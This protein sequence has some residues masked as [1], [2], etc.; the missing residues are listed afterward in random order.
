MT[1]INKDISFFFNPKSIAVVGASPIAEKLSNVI[2]NSLR[3]IGFTG[4]IY[5]VNPKYKSI[6]EMKCY[7]SAKAIKA[8]VDVAIICVPASAVLGVMEDI[9]AKKVKGVIIVSA[10]FKETGKDGAEAEEELKKISNE[11]GIR[12]IGPNCLGIFDNISKVDTFFILRERAKRPPAGG[13]SILSQ[14]GSFAGT[15]MDELSAEG[16]GVARIINYGNRADVGESDCLEY[17]AEDKSTKVVGLYIESVDNGKIF[18]EAARRCS[19]K[20]PVF[21][22]KA[23]RQ[24]TGASAARSHTGAI[25]GRYEIYSA[26]FK[27]AGIIEVKGYSEFLD[28]CK[29]LSKQY[30]ADGKRVL[31]V[32]DGG[33]MGAS[34]ADACSDFGLVVAEPSQGIKDALASKLP[35]FC[36]VGNPIDLTGSVT[37]DNYVMA[38]KEAMSEYDAAIVM[39]L[40]GPP[41]LTD[42][43]IKM[44]KAASVGI[45]KPV[46][47]C[48]PGGE[49]SQK[50]K[51]MFEEAGL[52]V[53]SSPE[54][55]VRAAAILAKMTVIKLMY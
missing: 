45:K 30:H 49:Y 33:G 27:K 41:L 35:P 4:D 18:I 1:S 22:I 11:T 29:V 2:I 5:P 23:G 19:A 15:I 6:D 31:I 14:S 53:F 26:A 24:E 12:I 38:L 34:I 36:A 21:A 50:R 44:L 25:A 47:I 10:G 46:I 40:W 17:M 20:K 52:P 8:D 37:N 55:A 13:L 48:S 54:E 9:V 43:L 3:D 16:L 32:T 42:G 51:K 7:Q 39:V 28:A